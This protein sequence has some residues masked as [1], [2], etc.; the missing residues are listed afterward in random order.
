[1]RIEIFGIPFMP[2]E[3]IMMIFMGIFLLL[4]IYYYLKEKLWM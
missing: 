4:F 2:V 3:I 1:M